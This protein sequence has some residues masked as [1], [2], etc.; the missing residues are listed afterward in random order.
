[1]KVKV[2]TMR[3]ANPQRRQELERQAMHAAEVR[4]QGNRQARRQ[5][6][7]AWKRGQ[8]KPVKGGR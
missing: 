1:M 2:S 5:R 4:N 7:K 8:G 6:A 3:E